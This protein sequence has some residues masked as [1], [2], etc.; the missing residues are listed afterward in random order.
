[1]IRKMIRYAKS[2]F[3][4]TNRD[5]ANS[6]SNRHISQIVS[7]DQSFLLTIR[8]SVYRNSNNQEKNSNQPNQKKFSQTAATA[9]A[10]D[11][12]NGKICFI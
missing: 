4:D 2:L 8:Y 6:G 1:M 5:L 9:H 3:A 7:F 10:V 12:L 11:L